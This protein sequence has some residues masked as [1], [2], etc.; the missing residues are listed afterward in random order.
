MVCHAFHIHYTL[1]TY[2]HWAFLRC[3]LSSYR[4][5]RLV[6]FSR[7][8]FPDFSTCQRFEKMIHLKN[9]PYIYSFIQFT[10]MEHLYCQSLNKTQTMKRW[11]TSFLCPN[12]ALSP[13]SCITLGIQLNKPPVENHEKAASLSDVQLGNEMTALSLDE[14]WAHNTQSCFLPL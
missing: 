7:V 1:V 10:F 8:P 4:R 11:Q 5:L 14:W 3:V 2:I 12:P 9:A 6:R 13:S